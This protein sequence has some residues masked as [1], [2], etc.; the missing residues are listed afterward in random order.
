[1]IELLTRF[2]WVKCQLAALG[3]CHNLSSLRKPLRSLPKDLDDTYARILQSIDNDENSKLVV[4]I[5][6]WLAYS[7]EPMSLAEISEALTIDP[8]NDHQF[9][10]ERR[11]E[12]PQDLLRICSSL[13]ATVPQIGEQGTSPGSGEILQFA[14]FSVREYLESPRI[15]DGPAKRYAIQERHSNIFIAEGCIIYLQH[16]D[17]P[18]K[19]RKDDLFDFLREEYP[20]AIYAI[21]HWV[22]HAERAEEG[23]NIIALSKAF[24]GEAYKLSRWGK[25]TSWGFS[26]PTCCFDSQARYLPLLHASMQNVPKI[27]SALILEGA[28]VNASDS[29]DWTPLMEI[30]SH[31][32][33]RIELVRLLLKH[34]ADVN[35]QNKHGYTAVTIAAS[36]RKLQTVRTLLDGGADMHVASRK[37][38]TVLSEAARYGHTEVVRLLLE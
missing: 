3:R 22:F 20:F 18:Q 13:V 29:S 5:V 2:Q 38:N 24:T 14:H 11:L 7:R 15:H 23:G 36:K 4:T 21:S 1:M 35:A 10:V 26:V 33:E 28:D 6:Q 30:S 9:D 32:H 16:L 8:D 37:G 25:K 12:D 19:R 17:V 31:Q 27:T 34:G